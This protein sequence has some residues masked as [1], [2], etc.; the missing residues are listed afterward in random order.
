M[1]TMYIA[2]FHLE[3]GIHAR[4]WNISTNQ[5]IAPPARLCDRVLCC[6]PPTLHLLHVHACTLLLP[7]CYIHVHTYMHVLAAPA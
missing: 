3:G 1:L 6:C 2:E 7:H 5:S 4:T